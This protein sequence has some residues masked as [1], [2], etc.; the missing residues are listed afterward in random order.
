METC[1]VA[2]S[3]SAKQTWVSVAAT[4]YVSQIASL[5]YSD[6]SAEATVSERAIAVAEADCNPDLWVETAADWSRGPGA[7]THTAAAGCAHA[8]RESA[9]WNWSA[10]AVASEAAATAVADCGCGPSA[11]E[12]A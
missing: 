7:A 11:A 12:N 8:A 3:V 9:S 5:D 10:C 1:F 2:E 6:L 4:A